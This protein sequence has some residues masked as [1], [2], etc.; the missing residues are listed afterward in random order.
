MPPPR[1]QEAALLVLPEARCCRRGRRLLQLREASLLVLQEAA[2]PQEADHS[3][4]LLLR[5]RTRA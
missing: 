4:R 2:L 1:P 3:R 5:R